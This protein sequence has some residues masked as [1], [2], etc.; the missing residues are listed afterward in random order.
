MKTEN[1]NYLPES[2]PEPFEG[3]KLFDCLV[4]KGSMVKTTHQEKHF[5]KMRNGKLNES[6]RDWQYLIAWREL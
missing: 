5:L 6:L 2:Q 4:E 1:W 3:I